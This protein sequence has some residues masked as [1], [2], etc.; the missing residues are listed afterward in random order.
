ML[1]LEFGLQFADLYRRDG[2][3]RVD[4]AF[5]EQLGAADAATALR[6][7]AARAAPESLD[8]KSESAL[9]LD[10]APHLDRFIARLFGIADEA[11]ALSG[12]HDEL[13]PLYEIKRRFVQRHAA[14]KIKAPEAE[15]LDGLAIEQELKSLFGGHFDE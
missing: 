1:T 8:N 5:V 13:A 2:L 3:T 12:R 15:A 9:L 11:L 7:T 14:S 6:L 10:M 4:A